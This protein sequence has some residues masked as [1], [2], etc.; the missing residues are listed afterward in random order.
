MTTI[1]AVN[2]AILEIH[3]LESSLLDTED[4]HVVGS[5]S[6][7]PLVIWHDKGKLKTNVLGTKT[8]TTLT[9]EVPNPQTTPS[10]NS[11]S[12]TISTH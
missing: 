6:S 10:N 11:M 7:A 3:K 8:V 1:D 9:S 5:H 4:V 12:L 2:G